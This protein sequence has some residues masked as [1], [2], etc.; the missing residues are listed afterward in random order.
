MG[1]TSTVDLDRAQAQ[2]ELCKEAFG[3]L[4]LDA[5]DLKQSGLRILDV[6]TGDGFWVHEIR[7][8]MKD[9]ESADLVGSDTSLIPS[10]QRPFEV[11]YNMR[12][13]C[14]HP[15]EEWPKDLQ[16]YFDLV[17]IRAALATMA[18]SF[19]AAV[20]VVARLLQLVKPGGAIVLIDRCFEPGAMA[21]A[22]SP[23]QKLFK[24]LG[25]M[26]SAHGIDGTLGGELAVI[27][28]SASRKAGIEVSDVGNRK[29]P[30]RIGVGAKD[31]MEEF[32]YAWLDQLLGSV[33]RAGKQT[34]DPGVVS[35]GVNELF[36][37][38]MMEAK[39]EG[40]D[41]DWY[42]AWGRRKDHTEGLVEMPA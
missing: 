20:D 14:Q 18:G 33:S 23:N 28:D 12:F 13:L 5:V 19:D 15:L 30:S 36:A 9:P 24:M 31:G 41:V 25:N 32:G 38:T 2:H 1:S 42:A 16:G 40:F 29:R 37:Q 34:D 4:T 17:H 35:G 39:T 6:G 10:E 3:S 26:F 7:S 11:P 8:Q 22:D 27:L 21:P